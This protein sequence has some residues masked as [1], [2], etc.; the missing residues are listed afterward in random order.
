M[1]KPDT[2]ILQHRLAP[3]LL[4]TGMV[5]VVFGT[6]LFHGFVWDDHIYLLIKP[7][8][9]TFDLRRIFLSLANDLEYLPVRD[10][11]YAVDYAVW[12]RNP[13]GFHLTSLVIYTLTVLL[14][15]RLAWRLARLVD[16]TDPDEAARGPALFCA[17]LF[18]VHPIHAEVASF[19][20][21]RNTLLAGLFSVLTCLLFLRF[22]AEPRRRCAAYTAALICFLLALLSKAISITLPL[23][24]VLT[25][26]YAGRC[27]RRRALLATLPFLALAVGAFFLFRA[28]AVASFLL[29][30]E[31]A[32]FTMAG[33]GAKLVVAMQIPLFYLGKLL[34]PVGLH[35]EYN[36]PFNE[37]LFSPAPLLALFLLVGL[38][39]VAWQLRTRFP[40]LPVGVGWFL[41]TL[42]PVLHLFPTYPVVA[43][44][45]AYLPSL[46]F[47]LSLAAV[48]NSTARGRWPRLPAAAATL[49][50]LALALLGWQQNRLWQSDE[51]LWRHTIRVSPLSVKAYTNLGRVCFKA[52]RYEEAFALFDQARRLAPTD[53]L[54]DFHE[55][56]LYYIRG[57]YPRALTS[58]S[59][60]LARDGLSLEALFHTG[61]THE[62]LGNRREA[63]AFFRKSSQSTRDDFGNFRAMARQKMQQLGQP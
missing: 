7:A 52:G 39:V 43:D 19:I 17:A 58:F 1:T 49:T 11:S 16:P 3:Y 25:A 27:E 9:L 5:A 62:A 13:L 35:P 57:D 45:Y 32:G 41:L 59:Q 12:G 22:L 31:E 20:T 55:G 56:F 61:L 63:I 50:C 2:S 54:Y 24:L 40:L 48:G 38:A 4:L 29:P 6:S 53:P 33:L 28:I 42:V 60:A 44:R 14:V 18:A 8:Y 36:V 30:R 51:L 21:G 37:R 15:F 10:L 46:G 26:L 47:C 34:V 23:I